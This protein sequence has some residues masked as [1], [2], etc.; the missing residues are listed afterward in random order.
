MM[1]VSLKLQ[2]DSI[3]LRPIEKKDFESFIELTNEQSM[4]QYF[5][6]DLSEK[7]ELKEW[8]NTALKQIEGKS[9][10]AFSIVD[11]SN[12][13]VVGSTSFGNISCKDKRLEI[14]WT[15]LGKEYQGKGINSQLKHLM[16]GYCFETA[17]YERVEFKTDVLNIPARK[18]LLKVG[19]VEEGVLRSHTLMTHNRRRDT[20]FYS[21][22]K[23]EWPEVKAKNNWF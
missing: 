16:L 17:G 6:S 8:V 22:L 7:T 9:R 2:T 18:A 13:R 15:W 3:L 14:G 20:I 10:L 21:I 5:T 23:S 11:K 1:D 19:M 4:W 12:D